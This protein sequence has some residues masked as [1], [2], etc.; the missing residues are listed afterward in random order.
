MDVPAEQQ[1]EQRAHRVHADARRE[2]RHDR[3]GQR[4]E[5]ARLLVESQLQV[6]GDASR[7]R[8]VIERHHEHADERHRRNRAHPV[9]VAGEDAVFRAACRHADHFLR[10]E[11]GRQKRESRDPRGHRAAGQE[12]LRAPHHL[13]PEQKADGEHERAVDGDQQDVDRSEVHAGAGQ[14]LAWDAGRAWEDFVIVSPNLSR[15]GPHGH[16]RLTIQPDF[17]DQHAGPWFASARRR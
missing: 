13:P 16:A 17:G 12:E 4:V 15:E 6:F 14:T 10:A 8:A 5:A 1:R 3:E 7:V 9:E 2:H 11:I